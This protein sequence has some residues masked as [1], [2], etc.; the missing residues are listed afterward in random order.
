MPILLDDSLSLS[1]RD[2][3]R[4]SISSLKIIFGLGSSHRAISNNVLNNFS[5]FLDH[6]LIPNSKTRWNNVESFVS[7]SK[8]LA[9]FDYLCILSG[10]RTR[11]LSYK[12]LRLFQKANFLF[13]G[14]LVN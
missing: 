9:K 12:G 3:H 2:E 10:I 13:A 6:F 4:K 1:N 14:L 8:A 7:I 5:G 11:N